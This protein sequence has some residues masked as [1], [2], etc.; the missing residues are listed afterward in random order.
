[1]DIDRL[2][3]LPD[4]DE[5]GHIFNDE[6]SESWEP[7]HTLEKCKALYSQ[8][9][10]VTFLLNGL[11][12]PLIGEDGDKH[13]NAEGDSNKDLSLMLTADALIVAAKIRSSE[14]GNYYVVRMENAAVIRAYAKGISLTLVFMKING[15]DK[16]YIEVI[17]KEIDKFRL[18]FIEWINTF[19]K[20]GE[21]QLPDDWGLFV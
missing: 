9:Q 13:E 3:D 5:A 10:Q 17:R 8:W 19:E 18:L 4:W 14:S 1:M 6:N 7:N 21:F 20:E 12:G 11:L 2:S 15:I 16:Q